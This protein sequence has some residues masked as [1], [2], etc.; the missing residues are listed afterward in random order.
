MK[1]PTSSSA[2]TCRAA[3]WTAR[4]GGVA[5]PRRKASMPRL[6]LKPSTQSWVS[7]RSKRSRFSAG[8]LQKEREESELRARRKRCRRLRR[9]AGR[10][11]A[12]RARWRGRGSA[13]GAAAGAVAQAPSP[14]IARTTSFSA[15]PCRRRRS[16]R[17]RWRVAGRRQA[18]AAHHQARGHHQQTGAGGFFQVVVGEPA[19]RACAS[20]TRLAA[21]APCSRFRPARCGVPARA[22]G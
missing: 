21:T 19:Q 7:V 15:A 8:A 16:G 20:C 10:R 5:S 17:P 12:E 9:A 13:L 1:P 14:T 2:G 11:R 6:H 3:R 22:A 4:P 18:Q